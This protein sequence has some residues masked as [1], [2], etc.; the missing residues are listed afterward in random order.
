MSDR[1]ATPQGP[2]ERTTAPLSGHFRVPGDKSISH[3][4]LILA[5][6][7]TGTSRI[8]GLLEGD[9]VL[10]TAQSMRQLGATVCDLGDGV[11]EVA[12]CGPAGFK[13]PTH[14]LDFGN[15][16]TGARLVMG[17]VAGA[18]ISAK[19]TG[20]A[21][22]SRRPMARVTKPLAQTG[23][24]IE[25]NGTSRLPLTITGAAQPLPLD[26]ASEFASAQVKSAILL[27]GLGAPG[28]TTVREKHITRDHTENMLAL[29]GAKI[30]SQRSGAEN[31]VTLDG[32]ARLRAHDIAV[33]GDPSSAA[34]PL[35]A[36]LIVPG[37]KLRLEN[38]LLNPQRDGLIR[39][40]T[41]M[42]ANIKR[43]NERTEAGEPIADLDVAYST[44]KGIEVG[45]DMAPSMIDEYPALAVAA[46]FAEG[47]T[48][49]AGLGELRV[50]ESDRLAAV[51]AGLRENGVNVEAG[52]DSLSVSGGTPVGG[53]CVTTHDDHRIAMAFLVMG[54]ATQSPVR[55]DD[56]AMIA[57]SF[58]NFF[59]AMAGI[60]A[61]F[62]V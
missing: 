19:F 6:M 60:G 7:A 22:L 8:T 13:T 58:P 1:P 10:A 48:H 44:L 17:V 24:Q 37:S 2:N 31:I 28:K 32:H 54:L 34:F 56:T 43:C 26:V 20:D 27:A 5:A 57:T 33:P 42:G 39:T 3:R 38:V 62:D 41:R 21:S 40:L 35:V 16:G 55:V 9:D 53:A 25:D 30:S 46:A 29:F 15:S 4:A 50:K 45:A 49:M 59:E 61:R 52:T 51:E 47:T 12:G 11:W 23:A 18:G 14:A 36:A